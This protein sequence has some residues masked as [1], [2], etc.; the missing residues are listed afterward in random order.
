[1]RRMSRHVLMFPDFIF[2]TMSSPKPTLSI[3]MFAKTTLKTVQAN[4]IAISPPNEGSRRLGSRLE[5]QG[6]LVVC[7]TKDNPC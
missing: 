2:S 4:H 6:R 7:R 3:F 1:L 5:F